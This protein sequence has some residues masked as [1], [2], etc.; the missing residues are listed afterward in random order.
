ML[1]VLKD[2]QRENRRDL[3]AAKQEGGD[4]DRQTVKHHIHRINGTAQLLDIKSLM[5]AAQSLEAKLSG[6][7][8]SSEL[9][10]ELEH[11]ET[12]LNELDQAIN[13][14]IP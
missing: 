3:L 14:F 4:G 2:A 6:T 11:M 1:T 7:I 13:N 12:L 8:S 9:V 10:R 5:A